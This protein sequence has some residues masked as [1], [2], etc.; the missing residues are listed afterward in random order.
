MRIDVAPLKAAWAARTPRERVLLGV[1]AVV[2]GVIV[3]WYG[4]VSPLRAAAEDARRQRTAAAERLAR[5][6]DLARRIETL[7]R[8]APARSPEA[9]DAL[10]AGSATEAGVTLDERV[11]VDAGL[12][13]R[14]TAAEAKAVFPWL[15][16]LQTRHGLRVSNLTALRGQG[17]TVE[18]EAV[19][20]G[21]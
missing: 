4:L 18:V 11:P 10:V 17:G 19:V 15:Q 6:E 14:A 20:S 3:V 5:V 12:R 2:A 16:S 21:G 8:T 9:L 13:V 1:M 7:S